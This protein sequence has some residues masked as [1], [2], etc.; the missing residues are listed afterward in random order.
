MEEKYLEIHLLIMERIGGDARTFK[1][2]NYYSL[3]T[4]WFEEDMNY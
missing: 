3:L 4:N 1:K 2:C